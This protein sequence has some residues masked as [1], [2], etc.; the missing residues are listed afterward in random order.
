MTVVP[1]TYSDRPLTILT[2]LY[3]VIP[4]TIFFLSWL[5]PYIG[6]ASTFLLLYGTYMYVKRINVETIAYTRAGCFKAVVV[7]LLVLGW[8]YCSGIG[9]YAHQEWDHNARNAILRDLINYDWPIYYT[10]PP[11]YH[12]KALAGRQSALNYY[13]T[14]WLPAA[15]VGK[16]LGERV[17]GQ[18]LFFWSYIGLLLSFYHL[19]RLLKFRYFL[20]G[21]VF[22]ILFG[23]Y[24]LYLY[25]LAKYAFPRLGFADQFAFLKFYTTATTTLFNPYN[26][27]IPGW[28]LSLYIVQKNSFKLHLLPVVLSFAYSPFVFVGL[29]LLNGL[30]YTIKFYTEGGTLITYLNDLVR[31]I[32]RIENSGTLVVLLIYGL[33]YQAHTKS[34]QQGPF[35]T[36]YFTPDGWQNLLITGKYLL[37]FFS[38]VGVYLLFIY[39]GANRTYIRYRLWYWLTFFVLLLLPLWVIG[40]NSDLAARASIPWLTILCIMMI[41][42]LNEFRTAYAGQTRYYTVMGLL[43]LSFAFPMRSIINSIPNGTPAKRQDAI[44]SLGDPKIND[45]N[46]PIGMVSSMNNFYSHEPNQYLFYKFLAR[47]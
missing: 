34:V 2:L 43:A 46:D 22:F 30:C 45:T 10:F 19:H 29:V 40:V 3:C 38:E 8:L 13:F 41:V 15:S 27:A 18:A 28:L 17:A 23:N 6:V 33:F 31:S 26:Q 11:D 35:W 20:I 14:F 4:I 37:A 24:D 21:T 39:I 44:G 32:P 7:A 36:F 9:G 5:R 12:F 25:L 16:L 42:A 47:H 1:K